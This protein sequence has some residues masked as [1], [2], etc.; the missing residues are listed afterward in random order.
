MLG[1]GFERF[2]D[3]TGYKSPSYTYIP[4]LYGFSGSSPVYSTSNTLITN[5]WNRLW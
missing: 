5:Q 1:Y 2:Y 4:D 3:T